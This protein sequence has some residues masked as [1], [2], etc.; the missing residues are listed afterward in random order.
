MAAGNQPLTTFEGYLYQD[1]HYLAAYCDASGIAAQYATDP[2][3]KARLEHVRDSKERYL[4]GVKPFFQELGLDYICYLNVCKRKETIRYI[5]F[6]F[7][8]A[9]TKVEV[10]AITALTPCLRLYNYMFGMVKNALTEEQLKANKYRGWIEY[11]SSEAPEPQMLRTLLN[12]KQNEDLINKLS[13]GQPQDVLDEID[14]IYKQGLEH[15]LEF[16]LSQRVNGIEVVVPLSNKLKGVSFPLVSDFDISCIKS[17]NDIQSLEDYEKKIANALMQIASPMLPLDDGCFKHLLNIFRF[18]RNKHEKQKV[19]PSGD[20]LQ[21][22]FELVAELEK[23]SFPKDVSFGQ[24]DAES[25]CINLFLEV[26]HEDNLDAKAHLISTYWS[27]EIIKSTLLKEHLADKISHAGNKGSIESSIDKLEKFNNIVEKKGK[28][29][30]TLSLYIG[31][32]IGDLLCLREADIG[33]IYGSNEYLRQVM[34]HFSVSSVPLFEGLV[35]KQMKFKEQTSSSPLE[36]SPSVI[37]TFTYWA[38]LEVF[39]LGSERHVA[40]NK[41]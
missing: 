25:G 24:F 12:A 1:M 34:E 15:E 11:N 30:K 9:R 2:D 32:S 14:R 40:R 41:I 26:L 4:D 19:A 7:A 31:N 10:Y 38:E 39:I 17:N 35:Q 23:T 20:I 36:L 13:A 28:E 18:C 3:A 27:D 37:F 21:A 8:A 33:V 5:D 16:N 6:L 22:A 29:R